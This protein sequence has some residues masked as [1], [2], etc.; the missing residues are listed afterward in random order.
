ME[1]KPW[2]V[3]TRGCQGWRLGE[4]SG[5]PSRGEERKHGW[6][7]ECGGGRWVID[8]AGKERYVSHDR[9]RGRE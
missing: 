8:G 4:G 6:N 1:W 3:G 7:V 2:G 9:H 5:L